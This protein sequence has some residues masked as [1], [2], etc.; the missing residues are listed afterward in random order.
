MSDWPNGDTS[1]TTGLVIH[2][3]MPAR[4]RA[5]RHVKSLILTGQLPPGQRLA[6][7]PLAQSLGIS[8][9]PIR[10]ALHKLASEGLINSLA[11]RGFG[12]AQELEKEREELFELRALLEGHALR[13]ICGRLT[14]PEILEL[15]DTVRQTE[16]ALRGRHLG[17]VFQWNNR[18]H[19]TLHAL[20]SDRRRLHDQIVTMRQY[21]F[22]Y[23]DSSTWDTDGGRCTV[24]GHGRIVTALRLRDPDLCERVMREH[25]QPPKR[26]VPRDR[27]AVH[28]AIAGSGRLPGDARSARRA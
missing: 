17:D 22:R 15:D 8:R 26:P 25:I 12:A 10:E 1:Q 5:Y 20:I 16:E 13:V 4:E 19:E 14:E 2:N 23:W 21:A 18:F 7:E 27:G 11:A 28:Q 24:E 6:E 9:T 3:T